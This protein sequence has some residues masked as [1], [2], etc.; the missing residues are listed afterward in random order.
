LLRTTNDFQNV[1]LK[2]AFTCSIKGVVVMLL[3]LELSRGRSTRHTNMKA[4]Q[5]L[6][7]MEYRGTTFK[8]LEIEVALL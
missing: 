1:L 7:V 5:K 8:S 3:G 6:Y 2:P 4:C